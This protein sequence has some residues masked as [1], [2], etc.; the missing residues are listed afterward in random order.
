MGFFSNI[1][2]R[3]KAYTGKNQPA[4]ACELSIDTDK[5]LLQEFDIE[6][7]MASGDQ[8]VP[9]YAVFTEK[10]SPELESWINN[11]IKRKS[12]TVKFFRNNDKLSEGALFSLS[13]SGAV[14]KRYRKITRGE[15]PATTLTFV[16]KQ[17]TLLDEEF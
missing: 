15:N 13:F 6:L 10:L 12:G 7:N 8:C 9:M 5:Y 16:A 2:K 1:F 3:G 14:C 11:S 4:Y 17:V